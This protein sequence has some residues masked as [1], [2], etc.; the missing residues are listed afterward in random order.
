MPIRAYGLS[1]SPYFFQ[2]DFMF[3]IGDKVKFINTDPDFQNR[4]FTIDKIYTVGGKY[5]DDYNKWNM[6]ERIGIIADDINR[7]NGWEVSF[8]ELVPE[9]KPVEITKKEIKCKVVMPKKLVQYAS[10]M[11]IVLYQDSAKPSVANYEVLLSATITLDIPVEEPK[12][13]LTPSELELFIREYVDTD[14]K[15]GIR[16]F[17]NAK[18]FPGWE[19]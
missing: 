3:K 5:Q 7:E 11:D 4:G 1:Y 2:G 16:Q 9:S 8:F 19:P 17:L 18:L 10:P 6:D 12:T 13:T 14:N 15:R